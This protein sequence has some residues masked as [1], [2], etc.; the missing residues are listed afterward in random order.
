M[1][2]KNR[3]IIMDFL[4]FFLFEGAWLITITSV[5]WNQKLGRNSI[6][7]GFGTMG[8]TSLLATIAIIIADR[9]V[10]TEKLYSILQISYR[11]CL[12]YIPQVTTQMPLY[13]M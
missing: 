9:W 4:Q 2:V 8:I 3:L 6:W 11:G 7:F 13:I 12:F 1:G 10:N 5:V